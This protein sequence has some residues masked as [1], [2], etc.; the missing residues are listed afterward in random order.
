MQER[1]TRQIDEEDIGL[2]LLQV[3]REQIHC[4]EIASFLHFV[5]NVKFLGVMYYI[6]NTITH[7]STLDWNLFV[8]CYQLK[9]HFT[10]CSSL[11]VFE[12][13]SVYHSVHDCILDCW[14]NERNTKSP[15]ISCA[16]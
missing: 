12:L 5:L 11:L 8:P 13:S 15:K 6:Y 4:T 3:M 14:S 1:L 2:E 7:F 9:S 16:S 10:E